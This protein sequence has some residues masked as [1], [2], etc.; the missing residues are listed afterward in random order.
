MEETDGRRAR[1]EKSRD[2]VIN[3]TIDLV[4]E[5]RHPLTA[6]DISQRANVSM[7]SLFRYFDGLQELQLATIDHYLERYA[8]AFEITDYC[9]G[10]LPTRVTNLVNSRLALYQTTEPM[11][12]FVRSRAYDHETLRNGLHQRRINLTHQVASHLELGPELAQVVAVLTSFET[13]DQMAKD[14]L[15]T[16][17]QISVILVRTIHGLLGQHELSPEFA[18]QT[19]GDQ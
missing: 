7:S 19:N 3:A 18:S 6:E 2:A 16:T 4:Q 17:S 5:G 13:W 12:R 10:D 14:Y 15:R 8:T 9:R 11:A 1:T